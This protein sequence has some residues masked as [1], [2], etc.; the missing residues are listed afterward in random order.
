[1]LFLRSLTLLSLC[2]LPLLVQAAPPRPWLAVAEGSG[3]FSSY[4]ACISAAT[5]VLE[6]QGFVRIT[7]TG[8]TV[9]GA[10]Q[11][12]SDYQFKVAVKCIPSASMA[13]AFVTT[14]RSGEGLDRANSII[15]A[16]RQHVGG[17]DEV[18]MHSAGASET[19]SSEEN[20]DD[21]VDEGYDEGDD[22]D[23]IDDS[24][25]DEDF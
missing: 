25:T 23:D 20:Y 6:N 1:M 17:S 10:Y 24:D 22:M 21:S 15:A 9:M 5:S 3:L 4:S 19:L 14:T 12:G 11:S 8:T 16:L 13:V 18:T 7:N 2:C